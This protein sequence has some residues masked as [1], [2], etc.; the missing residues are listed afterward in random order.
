MAFHLEHY[1]TAEECMR[2]TAKILDYNPVND[3]L[4][5]LEALHISKLQ[6]AMK[7]EINSVR[8]SSC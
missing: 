2:S 1:G 3:T 5:T 8:M 7:T 4:L 6:A